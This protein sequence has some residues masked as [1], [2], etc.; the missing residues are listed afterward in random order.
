M[1][2]RNK[3][4]KKPTLRLLKIRKNTET[5]SY[6]VILTSTSVSG[7]V[8]VPASL[9]FNIIL[10]TSC[11][12]AFLD[13]PIKSKSEQIN[14]RLKSGLTATVLEDSLLIAKLLLVIGTYTF[15]S[16]KGIKTV[17]PENA[18]KGLKFHPHIFGQQ[19]FR[20]QAEL[21]PADLWRIHPYVCAISLNVIKTHL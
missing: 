3:Q 4:S 7:R 5:K 20:R 11:L 6:T 15:Y 17:A 21:S 16:K 14:S 10:Q 1:H 13:E 2:S 12:A 9:A 19:I 18:D 8:R